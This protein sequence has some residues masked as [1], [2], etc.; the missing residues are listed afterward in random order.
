MSDGYCEVDFTD[1]SDD[2]DPVEFFNYREVTARK[3]HRCCECGN[4]I[5]VGEKHRVA[6]YKFEGEFHSDRTCSP[7]LE[8]AGE[9]GYQMLGGCFWEMLHDEWDQGARVQACINRLTTA[10]AKEHMRQQWLRWQERRA[11]QHR[12]MQE[13]RNQAVA[14]DSAARS[15]ES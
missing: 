2:A 6:A 1:A 12:R 14:K 5:A 4:E 15:S 11:G 9:F 13:L 7:C 10:R 3:P 8:A